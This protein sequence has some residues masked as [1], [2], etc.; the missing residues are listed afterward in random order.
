MNTTHV[1]DIAEMSVSL[2]A[3]DMGWSVLR[4][5]GNSLPYDLIIDVS[6]SLV[7]IQVKSAWKGKPTKSYIVESRRTKTNRVRMVRA[8]YTDNDFDFAIVYIPETKD[9]YI[10]PVSEFIKYKGAITLSKNSRA[11]IYLNSWEL[12]QKFA[13]K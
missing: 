4:P 9:F 1:G 13:G 5:V 11:S 7:K 2:A 3:M 10:I 12:I 8:R 6:G